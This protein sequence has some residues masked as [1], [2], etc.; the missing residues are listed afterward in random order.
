MRRPIWASI[1]LA[2]MMVFEGSGVAAVFV[3]TA[4]PPPRSVGVIGRPPGHGFVWTG[5][6]YRWNR[7][8]YAWTPGRGR[9]PP[10]RGAVWVAPAW[11]PS[12]GGWVFVDG[13]WR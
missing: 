4:P 8:R 5:G 2:A 3:R 13:R 6:Y 11:R 1:A 12:R 7:G 9:R 10:R